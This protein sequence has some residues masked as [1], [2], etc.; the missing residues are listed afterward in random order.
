M[1]NDAVVEQLEKLIDIGIALSAET[2]PVRLLERIL[3]S[4]M[5]LTLADGGTLYSVKGDVVHIDILRNLSLNMRI[6]GSKGQPNTLP[7]IPLYRPDGTPNVN[8]VVT[9]TIHANATVNIRD[10]YDTERF[11]FSGTRRFDAQTGY[12]STSMLTVPLRNHEDEIIG[13]LQLINATAPKDGSIIPFDTLTQR[14]IEALASQTAIALTKEQLI[15]EMKQLFEALIQLIADAIDRKSPY[16]GGH[17]R[18]V[19]AI[20]MALAEAAHEEDQGPL[21]DFRLTN[22]DRYE[23]EIASWLHDCGKITTPEYVV[24]KATKLETICDRIHWIENRFEILKRDAETAYLK[25]RVALAN[26]GKAPDPALELAYQARCAELDEQFAFLKRCNTGGEFMREEDQERVRQIGRQT[27][28]KDG[29]AV[30]LLSD[31]EVYNL[32]IQRGTLTQ[33]E[34]H[35]INDHIRTTIDMLNAL[36]FPKHLRNVP[37]YAG[38]HHERMDGKGYPQGLTREQM[39]VQARILGI[40]D[41]FEALTACDRPYKS[42][43]TLSESLKIMRHMKKDGH[44]DPDLFDIFVRRKIYLEYA[45]RFLEPTQIDAVDAEALLE[46][47]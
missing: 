15:G 32:T 34:R 16:T 33:E 47:S 8:N 43:K 31:N 10:S 7:T 41:I 46:A 6:G 35:V 18:R 12:R 39:S 29:E 45:E 2:E 30:P 40:A 21:R 22:Q 14:L 42:A 20:A 1:A 36:P 13:V 3:E 5:K 11:D 17:C 26:D 19:P 44:I 4:A 23:L 27:W 38:G 28:L 37:E 25:Q 9:Y 24:D